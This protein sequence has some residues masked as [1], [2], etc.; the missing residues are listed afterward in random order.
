MPWI[1]G[2]I[3]HSPLHAR[4]LADIEFVREGGHLVQRVVHAR[5]TRVAVLACHAGIGLSVLLL[6][7]VLNLIPSAVLYGVFLFLAV[8]SLPGNSFYE[9]VLLIF[10]QQSKYPPHHFLR[11]VPQRY[12][13]LFTLFQLCALGLLC[14]FGF[15]PVDYVQV[16]YPLALI[17]LPFIR[18]LVC[19]L[20]FRRE[21]ILIL[22]RE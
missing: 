16:F 2:G 10:T 12:I 20:F 15:V 17:S 3:P 21:H 8:T 18:F 5:E 22:D 4:A 1:N 7:N 9:R 6:D 14:T 13:H 19:P 11:R